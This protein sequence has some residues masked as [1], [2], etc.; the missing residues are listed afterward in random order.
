M[1]EASGEGGDP[2]MVLEDQAVKEAQEPT[3]QELDLEQI[4]LIAAGDNLKG[5]TPHPE[6]RTGWKTVRVFVS[7]TFRDFHYER[8]VLVKKVNLG[9]T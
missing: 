4:W 6:K 5:G 7:S 9:L 3:K 8:D 2:W 1:A